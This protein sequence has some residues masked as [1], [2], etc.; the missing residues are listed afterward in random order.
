LSEKEL[1]KIL[2]CFALKNAASY[3]QKFLTNFENINYPHD[4]LRFIITYGKSIDFT[5]EIIQKWFGERDFPYEIYHE[6]IMK[7]LT[8]D[9]AYLADLCN[10]WLSLLKDEKYV[11]FLDSDLSYFP[12]DIF[13]KLLE[14][15][16]D[17]VAPYVYIEGTQIF[18]DT[19]VFRTLENKKYPAFNPPSHDGKKA[20]ELQSVGTFFLCKREVIDAGTRWENPVPALQF[21]KNARKLGFK[22]WAL[23]YVTINHFDL[24]KVGQ[25][26]H[27]PIEWYISQ[28]II[29][30]SEYEKI[31]E[32][33]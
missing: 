32:G 14:S 28:G 20:I 16:K 17:I 21:C 12:P 25:S 23:P 24:K 6:P 31:K 15:N 18:Y 1:P 19:Y 27:K 9:A 2:I 10:E 3:L 22:V 11:L 29:P 33:L 13:Q 8:D 30:K 4:K 7:K 26:F 5:L